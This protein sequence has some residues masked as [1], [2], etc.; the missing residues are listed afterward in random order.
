MSKR[1][2]LHHVDAYYPEPLGWSTVFGTRGETRGFCEGWV[3]AMDSLYP[4][5][6]HRII[7]TYA[8]GSTKLIRQTPGRASPHLNTA[9]A[10]DE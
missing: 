9:R 10:S 6:P 3:S 4:S 1:A 7:A 8:D 5:R 2:K